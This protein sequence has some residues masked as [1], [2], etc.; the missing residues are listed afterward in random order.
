MYNN[1]SKIVTRG[2]CDKCLNCN[3]MIVE[4]TRNAFFTKTT[5]NS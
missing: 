4:V 1:S 2:L 3:T 5:I